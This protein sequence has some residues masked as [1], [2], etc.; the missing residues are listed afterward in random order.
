M[1]ARFSMGADMRFSGPR[2]FALFLALAA[3]VLAIAGAK[4]HWI[5]VLSGRGYGGSVFAQGV[6]ASSSP[7]FRFCAS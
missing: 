4:L 1:T 7:T 3:V 5:V 6:V 2:R